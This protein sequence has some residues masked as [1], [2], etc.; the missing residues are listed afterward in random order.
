[1]AFSNKV[2][3]LLGVFL[4]VR[5]DLFLIELKVSPTN[6]IIVIIDGDN[7]V[8]LQDCLD[9]SRSIENNLDREDQDFSLQVHSFGLS[10]SLRNERQYRKNVGRELDVYLIDGTEISGELIKTTEDTIT[11]LLKYRKPKEIGKGKVDGEEENEIE[12]KNI[13]KTLVKIKF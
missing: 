10:E 8:T 4:E 9:A 1:M 7:G 11:L 6:D 13:K 12:Y 3:E 2:E 5:E